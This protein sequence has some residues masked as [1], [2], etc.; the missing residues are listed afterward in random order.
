M[1][2]KGHSPKLL[3]AVQIV[4]EILEAIWQ[5]LLLKIYFD[6]IPT[7]VTFSLKPVQKNRYI[8]NVYHKRRKQKECLLMG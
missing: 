2:R 5:H 1:S 8:N 3:V 7:T 6:E 4:T